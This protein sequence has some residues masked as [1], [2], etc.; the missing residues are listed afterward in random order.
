LP[1]ACMHLSKCRAGAFQAFALA[2]GNKTQV[3]LNEMDALC[4][5][6]VQGHREYR[7]CYGIP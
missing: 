1:C 5:R 2:V 4:D 3:G 6:L 7:L